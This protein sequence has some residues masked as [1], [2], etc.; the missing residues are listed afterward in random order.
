MACDDMVTL[1]E[2][3]L[4]GEDTVLGLDVTTVLEA[5]LTDANTDVGEP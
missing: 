4:A 1:P 2:Y 3:V 5:A